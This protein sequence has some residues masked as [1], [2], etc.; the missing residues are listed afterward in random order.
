MPVDLEVCATV[1]E[2]KDE[3]LGS[4]KENDPFQ[5]QRS[6]AGAEPIAGRGVKPTKKRLLFGS[7][8]ISVTVAQT[9]KSTGIQFQDTAR[10]IRKS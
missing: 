10:A 8:F 6:T 7:S 9:S 1:T 2:M 5:A 3:P 4:H